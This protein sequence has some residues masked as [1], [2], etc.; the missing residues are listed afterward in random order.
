MHAKKRTEGSWKSKQESACRGSWQPNGRHTPWSA[1]ENAV[2]R[3]GVLLLRAGGHH[4]SETTSVARMPA[5]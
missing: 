2:G 5:V 1:R 3:R 4:A